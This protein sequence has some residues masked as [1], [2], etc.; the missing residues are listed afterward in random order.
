M[1]VIKILLFSCLLFLS[2]YSNSQ[3]S[4]QWVKSTGSPES[5]ALGINTDKSGNVYVIGRYNDAQITIEGITLNNSQSGTAEIFVAKYD[6]DGVIIWAKS[7]GGTSNDQGYSIVADNNGNTY[8]TGDY[9]SNNLSFEGTEILTKPV[10]DLQNAAYLIKLGINGNFLW[11]LNIAGNS[12]DY[13]RAVT[14]NTNQNP[15][16]CADFRSTSITIETTT[17]TNAG[18]ADLLLAEF[19]SADGSLIWATRAGGTG[20]EEFSGVKTD[21]NSNIYVSGNYTSNTLN[22]GASVLNNP[23]GNMDILMLKFDNIGTPLWAK[24]KAATNLEQ[25]KCI[26]IDSGNNVYFG[27]SKNLWKEITPGNWQIVDEGLIIKYNSAG[28]LQWERNFGYDGNTYIYDIL[29]SPQDKIYVAGLFSG[30]KIDFPSGTIT[31]SSAGTYDIFFTQYD[32]SGNNSWAQKIGGT[33]HDYFAG[34][35]NNICGQFYAAGQSSSRW[36]KFGDFWFENTNSPST[37]MYLAK[38]ASEM[39]ISFSATHAG[40]SG[41]AGAIDIEVTNGIPIYQYLWTPG[42]Q[43]S[44]DINSLTPNRYTVQVTDANG[45]V[46]SKRIK[47]DYPCADNFYHTWYFGFHAGLD[48]FDDIPE[49]YSDGKTEYLEGGSS[50]CDINGNLLFYTDGNTVWDRRHKVMPNGTGLFANPSSTQSAVIVPKPGS[51][52][53]YY[54]F[55][56]DW[57]SGANGLCYSIVDMTLNSGW[58]NITVK[59]TELSGI[60]SEKLTAIRHPNGTDYQIFSHEFGDRILVYNLTSTGV[61]LLKS[62]QAGASLGNP[63]GQMKV[64]PKVDK[65]VC[66]NIENSLQIFNYNYNTGTSTLL[67]SKSGTDEKYYGAE[68]SPSGRFLYVSAYTSPVTVNRVIQFDLNAGSESDILAS[69]TEIFSENTADFSFYGSLQIAPNGIIYLSRTGSTLAAIEKPDL[70]GTDCSFKKEAVV[71]S[72]SSARMGLPQNPAKNSIPIIS[73]VVTQPTIGNDGAIDITTTNGISPYSSIWSPGGQNTS[74]INGLSGGTYTISVFDS[75]GCNQKATFILESPAECSNHQNDVWI[76]G[77]YAGLDFNTPTRDPINVTGSAMDGFEGCA[78]IADNDGNLLFY[79]DGGTVWNFNNEIIENGTDLFSGKSSAQSSLIVPLSN[80]LFYLFTTDDREN[81]GSRGLNYHI[82]DMKENSGSGKVLQKNINLFSPCGEKLA[83][84]QNPDNSFWILAMQENMDKIIAYKLNPDGTFE[85]PIFNQMQTDYFADWGTLKFSHDNKTISCVNGFQSTIEIADF[86]AA[87]GVISNIRQLVPAGGFSSLYDTEFSPD[88]KKLYVIEGSHTVYQYDLSVPDINSIT[89]SETL[90]S[91]STFAEPGMG[92]LKLAPNNKIY[93]VKWLSEL[94][95]EIEF[96]DLAGTACNFNAASVTLAN[97]NWALIGLPNQIKILYPQKADFLAQN[98]CGNSQTQF[99][100]FKNSSDIKSINWNFGDTQNNTSTELNPTHLYTNPGDYTVNAEIVSDCLGTY[101]ITKNITVSSPLLIDA[102]EDKTLC[103]GE[104]IFL[105]DEIVPDCANLNWINDTE[106]LETP[107]SSYTKVIFRNNTSNTVIKTYTYQI[108]PTCTGCPGTDQ[109]QI[110]FLPKNSANS[111][112]ADIENSFCIDCLV[113]NEQTYT[114]IPEENGGIFTLNGT[115]LAGNKFNFCGN[116]NPKAIEGTNTVKY[117]IE[118]VNHCKSSTSKNFNFS[119]KISFDLGNDTTICKGNTLTIDAGAGYD[120]YLWL[121]SNET[122]QTI[123]VSSS[124]IY[125]AE[126]KK[127]NCTA[128][129][130]ISLTI[131]DLTLNIGTDTSICSGDTIKIGTDKYFAKYD[132]QNGLSNE[133]QIQV[134]RAGK[135]SLKVTDNNNCSDSDT[136]NISEINFEI[137]LGEDKKICEGQTILL[138]AQN[139]DKYIWNTGATGKEIN[140]ETAGIYSLTATKDKCKSSDTIIF[141]SSPKPEI[142]Y[143]DRLICSGNYITIPDTSK[144]FSLEIKTISPKSYFETSPNEPKEYLLFGQGRYEISASNTCGS[145]KD[146]LLL[147]WEPIPEYILPKDTS[148]CPEEILKIS[149]NPEFI[150]YLWNTGQ[151]ENY[152]NISEQ[153]LYILEVKDQNCT[154][155]DSVNISYSNDCEKFHY[156]LI[157]PEAFS[158]NKD[159]KNDFFEIAGINNFAQ[160]Q[161]SVFNRWGNLVYESN[162]YNNQWDGKNNNKGENLPEGTYYFILTI[163]KDG[164]NK[165]FKGSVLLLR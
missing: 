45:C 68:F 28:T 138:S 153:G 144:D 140:I 5:G 123:K 83:G 20:D 128:S 125:R 145:D 6:K 100:L 137:N 56:T 84:I 146:T 132:W 39:Q 163:D 46:Q 122:S 61:S 76:F 135:Y 50:I 44:Q 119:T 134:T 40:I 2:I 42:G 158:P 113:Q 160:N 133:K 136:I 48:F 91:T 103:Y 53:L 37:Q 16:L 95:D 31:N 165:I 34:I 24:T 66:A 87:N 139:A 88:S 14:L 7:I 60:A 162:P 150:Y 72:G 99:Q 152:I 13:G 117:S 159:G 89:A 27:C 19:N 108:T 96:P 71:F 97:G 11:A 154:Y 75:K 47:V 64:S 90:I 115:E 32:T 33:E 121:G 93:I 35:A 25:A 57:Y 74:D 65:I 18:G 147:T 143:Q 3:D 79:T 78:S 101:T 63:A 69:E 116:T 77:V 111:N 59:N 29:V 104:E 109:V 12:L 92:N 131:N 30:S 157:I 49:T 43:T 85:T 120:S 98:T 82:I 58:G 94:V 55:T 38:Y 1:K 110:T 142:E 102:G 21:S 70:K 156:D 151:T 4:W 148:I 36:M 52:T 118:D 149:A 130:D 105:G 41:N 126:V 15:I 161:I 129:S 22:F 124:G 81:N 114:L 106:G 107:E 112:F 62:Q 164:E 9:W 67:A 8:I 10:G 80:N 54:I 73:G 141:V 23:E 86:D 17:L 155:S 26:G 127:G 51:S